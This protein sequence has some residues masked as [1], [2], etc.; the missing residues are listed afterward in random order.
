MD[1]SK[2]TEAM[3]ESDAAFREQFDRASPEFHHGIDVP[4]P[5]GGGRVP[6]SMGGEAAKDWRELPEVQFSI[7]PEYPPEYHTAMAAYEQL[8]RVKKAMN[9]LNKPVETVMKVRV[10]YKDAEGE[11][12]IAMESR[13]RGEET[14]RDG[15]LGAVKASFDQVD[16]AEVSDRSRAAV[17]EVLERGAFA[18]EDRDTFGEFMTVLQRCNQ[19]VFADQ[20]KLLKKIKDIKKAAAQA[21]SAAK[22]AEAAGGDA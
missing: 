13:L 8:G 7:E 19:A 6:E 15:A 4:V 12:R 10:Q 16:S 20:T 14:N 9:V 1:I 3:I 18:F 21:P 17:A 22:A 5:T 2:F 11:A